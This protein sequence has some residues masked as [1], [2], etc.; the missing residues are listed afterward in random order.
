VIR[1]KKFRGA[2]I[3]AFCAVAL[4]L[5]AW[6]NGVFDAPDPRIQNWITD[7]YDETPHTLDVVAIGPSS[8]YTFWQPALAW[9]AFGIASWN[10]TSP[11][12]PCTA[13]VHMVKEVLKTQS[14]KLFVVEAGTFLNAPTPGRLH[15]L[16]DNMRWS[17]EKLA[18]LDE[19]CGEMGVNGFDR[20]E[21]FLPIVRF[22][23]RWHELGPDDFLPPGEAYKG[24]SYYA[25]FLNN[26]GKFQYDNAESDG[27]AP[28]DQDSMTCLIEF[29]DYCKANRLEVVFL[30]APNALDNKEKLRSIR[31]VVEGYGYPFVMTIEH[32]DEIGLKMPGDFYNE[33]HT[34]L[35]GSIKCV[36]WFGRYLEERYA[37]PDHRGEKG[38]ESWDS[39]CVD[40]LKV[41]KPH[42]NQDE[43]KALERT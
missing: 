38:Y 19:S 30:A 28:L 5:F 42:I 22:H 16:G 14:P 36:A 39:A 43:L 40:Y 31:T 11:S 27:E 3:I 18:L 7:F 25:T 20:L 1:T 17:P 34:N 12:M 9:D 26:S 35:H 8:M 37:L 4:L 23:E 2:E 15:S 13:P 10:M 24:S 33:K 41:I 32:M 21:Y 29:L 6:L